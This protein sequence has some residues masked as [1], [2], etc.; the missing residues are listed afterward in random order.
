MLFVVRYCS[1]KQKYLQQKGK[2]HILHL[3]CH[4]LLNDWGWHCH[5]C[6]VQASMPKLYLQNLL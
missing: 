4:W 6:T 2:E 3:D 5:L 1:P